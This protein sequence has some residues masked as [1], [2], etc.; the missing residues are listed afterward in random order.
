MAEKWTNTSSP[1]SVVMKPNPF[2]SLNH[3]TLPD[4]LMDESPFCAAFG[5]S[6]QRSASRAGKSLSEADNHR[7]WGRIP[8]GKPPSLHQPA[9]R[10]LLRRV[11]LDHEL[12]AAAR[13]Q[14]TP[15][16]GHSGGNERFN[17]RLSQ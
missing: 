15:G 9:S 2:A 14:R 17:L 13:W 1:F 11:R 4:V 12:A 7:G 3:F 16:L 10:P 5:D 6:K 8:S